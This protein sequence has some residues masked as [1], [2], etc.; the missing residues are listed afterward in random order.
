MSTPVNFLYWKNFL[1][2]E[3]KLIDSFYYIHPNEDNFE[4]YSLC[5]RSIILETC[6]DLEY[7]CKLLFKLKENT[8]IKN[9]LDV[10]NQKHVG[11]RNIEI[12]IIS[13]SQTIKPW[14]QMNEN[15]S[16][17]FWT[18]YNKIKH[19]SGIKE[20]TLKASLGALSALFS[21]LLAYYINDIENICNINESSLFYYPNYGAQHIIASQS[22]SIELPGF[23]TP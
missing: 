20:A 7:V 16:P 5:Y 19:K 14:F 10:I 3:K 12:Q 11:F 18:V 6:S 1:A 22:H 13:L 2:L 23:E 15:D 17:N 8:K 9:I 4:T 21:I